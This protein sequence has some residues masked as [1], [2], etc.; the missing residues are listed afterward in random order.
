MGAVSWATSR[1][2]AR[3]HPPPEQNRTLMLIM[4][5]T[6]HA[7]RREGRREGSSG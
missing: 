5:I 4:L 6:Y 1:S 2:D 7:W 3:V